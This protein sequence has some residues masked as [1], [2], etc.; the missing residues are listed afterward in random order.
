[1]RR[2]T[3]HFL[4]L[5]GLLVLT[6][7]LLSAQSEIRR[8]TIV[9]GLGSI[10]TESGRLHGS[11]AQSVAGISSNGPSRAFRFGLWHRAI[12]PSA[13]LLVSLPERAAHSGTEL[14]IP[15]EIVEVR[16]PFG[17]VERSFTARIRY[18]ASLLEPLTPGVVCLRVGDTCYLDI[19]GTARVA[20]GTIAEVR[21]RATLGN[22]TTTLL[23]VV[24]AAFEPVGEEVIR[25][26][27]RA[28]RFTLLGVCR[29]GGE[30][31]L[32]RTAPT[33]ARITLYP[34]PVRTSAAITFASVES[35]PTTLSL[36]DATGNEVAVLATFDADPERLYDI[37]TGLDGIA[38]GSYMLI[39]RTPSETLTERLLIIR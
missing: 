7:L 23:E 25:T 32:I 16:G 39:C 13:E 4:L 8:G 30:V 10:T 20:P 15:L 36:V 27:R 2:Q 26:N 38:G 5:S 1:M 37:T 28:G 18:N 31:R 24:E 3:G 29:E 19:A 33:A 21:F 12:A 6:P 34:N 9:A 22:D 17:D 11:L 14:T 35:G